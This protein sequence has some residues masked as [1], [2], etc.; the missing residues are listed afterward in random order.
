[1]GATKATFHVFTRAQLMRIVGAVWAQRIFFTKG[2]NVHILPPERTQPQKLC[3]ANF[4]SEIL[5]THKD[6]PSRLKK[7]IFF[8]DD[9]SLRKRPFSLGSKMTTR[10]AS[11]GSKIDFYDHL[12]LID[13]I[14]R[15]GQGQKF[16][17]PN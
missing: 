11:F 6:R 5:K 3:T 13:L 14:D 16:A 9:V 1:M 2:T 7:T 8:F 15:G 17:V 4:P 12:I 10:N